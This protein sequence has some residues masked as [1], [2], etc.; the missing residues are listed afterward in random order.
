M[1]TEQRERTDRLEQFI[2]EFREFR[3]Q[4]ELDMRGNK[5]IND[6]GS[7]GVIGEMRKLKERLEK[8]PSLTWL[9]A[10][11]PFQ[12]MAGILAVY[13]LLNALYT[14]GLIRFFSAFFGIAMP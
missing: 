13:V 9:F 3:E 5:E 6:K 4:Y 10:T 8:Y 12:T 1:A 2:R 7:C 14:V 11:R